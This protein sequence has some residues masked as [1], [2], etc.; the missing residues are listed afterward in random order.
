MKRNIIRF[1]MLLGASACFMLVPV[2]AEAYWQ[3]RHGYNS[4]VN[5]YIGVGS[6]S[7]YNTTRYGMRC[8]WVP[9]HM[10]HGYWYPKQKVCSRGGYY[11]QCQWVG[12]HWWR[13]VWYPGHKMCW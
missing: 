2:S 4:G 8:Q 13:G 3:H 12:G 6:G 10:Y 9:G 5:V 1:A 7:V 11:T